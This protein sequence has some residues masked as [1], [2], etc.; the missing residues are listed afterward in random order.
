M[1]GNSIRV[2]SVM[3]VIEDVAC[4][5]IKSTYEHQ[6]LLAGVLHRLDVALIDVPK[7]DNDLLCPLLTQRSC[8][9]VELALLN[10][11]DGFVGALARLVVSDDRERVDFVR[12]IEVELRPQPYSFAIADIPSRIE[13]PVLFNGCKSVVVKLL[14]V[15]QYGNERIYLVCFVEPQFLFTLYEQLQILVNAVASL[16]RIVRRPWWFRQAID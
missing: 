13:P 1:T 8:C 12:H 4:T 5:H 16:K 3:G 9:S 7:L 2:R 14:C 10:V 6:R 15:L 11:I